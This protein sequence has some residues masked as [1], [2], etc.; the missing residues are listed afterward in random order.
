MAGVPWEPD[1]ADVLE[2][3]SDISTFVVGSTSVDDTQ[4]P[5]NCSNHAEE[6]VQ[7][8][9]MLNESFEG[10][11][12]PT[13]SDLGVDFEEKAQQ[14]NVLKTSNMNTQNLHL[15][16]NQETAEISGLHEDGRSESSILAAAILPTQ[17]ITRSPASQEVAN[18]SDTKVQV[19]VSDNSTTA[20]QITVLHSTLGQVDE[21]TDEVPKQEDTY[22]TE[23]TNEQA[24][25]Q[26]KSVDLCPNQENVEN[27]LPCL[28]DQKEGTT[29]PATTAQAET[30]EALSEQSEI[31]LP[32]GTPA[33]DDLLPSI[34]HDDY[35]NDIDGP[36]NSDVVV[37]P[38][39]G[40]AKLNSAP[41]IIPPDEEESHKVQSNENVEMAEDDSVNVSVIKVPDI[42]QEFEGSPETLTT[43]NCRVEEAFFASGSADPEDA[44]VA[45]LTGG[46]AGQYIVYGGDGSQYIISESPSLEDQMRALHGP[47]P[48]PTLP[49]SFPPV[50]VPD[51]LSLVVQETIPLRLDLI[52][53]ELEPDVEAGKGLVPTQS[54]AWVTPRQEEVFNIISESLEVFPQDDFAAKSPLKKSGSESNGKKG[55]NVATVKPFNSSN[56]QKSSKSSKP[57]KIS[58]SPI[59]LKAVLSSH[60]T[61]SSTPRPPSSVKCQCARH[62]V[63]GYPP[64]KVFY[65]T[66]GTTPGISSTYMDFDNQGVK[67]LYDQ[68][69]LKSFQAVLSS[70][71]P[72][73]LN[74]EKSLEVSLCLSCVRWAENEHKSIK[75][76]RK[77]EVE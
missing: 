43:V 70:F 16:M 14:E 7:A 31:N 20:D 4:T 29:I 3:D 2:A 24:F 64:A 21:K 35:R 41:A 49:P 17:E 44:E 62:M 6:T 65:W 1:L 13:E 63:I 54:G 72:E 50:A 53:G 45:S 76:K 37:F 23:S 25:G 22:S 8:L 9:L 32:I 36:N 77:G 5:E 59:K 66:V 48:E 61:T 51:L 12:L 69:D 42:P 18:T 47:S 52:T 60:P 30:S 74:T 67:F 10:G 11:D 38:T 55:S 15:S 26:T 19:T 34:G 71:K 46:A 40:S 73:F 28:L 57:P 58:T 56:S 27:N 75:E 39:P 33:K 68:G